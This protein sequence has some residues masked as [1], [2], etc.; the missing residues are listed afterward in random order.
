M[1][2]VEKLYPR[3]IRPLRRVEYDRLVELGLLHEDENVELLYGRIVEMSPQGTAHAWAIQQL[4]ELLIAALA[5]RAKVRPQLPLALSDTSEPEPDLA[6]VAP[7]E[8]RLEHPTTALI[9][10]EVADSSLA[11]DRTIKGRLYAESGIPEYW[12]VN[13]VDGEIEVYRDPTRT[14]YLR[15]ARQGR[16]G[17]VRLELAGIDLKVADFVPPP[18]T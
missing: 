2:D 4:T 9:V 14:G 1:F 8:Y 13:L 3:R 7:G 11:S 5:G 16:D 17:M 10:I 12:L 18:T 15:A 6:V